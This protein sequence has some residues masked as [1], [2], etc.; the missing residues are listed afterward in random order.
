MLT[1]TAFSISNGV[2]GGLSDTLGVSPLLLLLGLG[3]LGLAL[4][5]A[6]FSSAREAA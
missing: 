1:Y 4:F 5:G 3:M 6:C 2:A